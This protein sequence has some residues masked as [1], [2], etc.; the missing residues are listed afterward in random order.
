MPAPPA[1]PPPLVTAGVAGAGARA[2]WRPGRRP[3]PAL[4][5][6]RRGQDAPG[7]AARRGSCCGRGEA[8]P[9]GSRLPDDAADAPVGA[10]RR[11]GSACSCSPT[12]TELR[13][14]RDF[15]GV[16]VTYARVAALG[17]SAGR[18]SAAPGTLVIADEAHH[19]GDELAWG[20]GFGQAFGADAALAAAVGH[21]VSLRRHAD[22]RRALRRRRRRACRT[23]ATRTP[24]RCATASAGRSPSSRT[25]ARCR[26][27][28]GDDVIEAGFDD[29]LAGREASRALP[30]GD[31]DRA[32][33][34]PAADPARGARAPRAGCAPAGTA[35]PAGWSSPPTAS[36]RGA[37]AKVLREVTG[38]APTVVVHTDAR[39]AEQA[40]R[41]SHG[42]ARALDRRGEHGLRGR[43]HPAPARRRLRDGGQDAA[44]LP[45]DR[46]ALRAHDRGPAARAE[47]ALPARPTRCCGATPPRSRREL[48]HVLRPPG[49]DDGLLDEPPE[50]RETRARPRRRTFVPL[51]ADVA[52]QMA[53]FGGGPPA[54]AVAPVA[55][56]AV[57]GARRPRSPARCPPSS[58]AARCATSA[59][60]SSSDLAAHGGPQPREIN[61]WLNRRLRRRQRRRGDP[62]AARALDRAAARRAHDPPLTGDGAPV[63]APRRGSW[64]GLL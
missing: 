47:L 18:G 32:R 49:E 9:R 59:T 7:L 13:P 55:R 10:G 54:P 43:R 2:R 15:H 23:S 24:T 17:A 40:A 50:R 8:R 22:P 46:R 25:T 28:S 33:R 64:G 45:P 52:P 12:P 37:V 30:H 36:T 11:R 48:R 56:R 1:H 62:R 4:R 38:D 44:D 41:R 20:E 42:V 35:T 57:A 21:A 61:A 53:L 5:R 14:P 26:G 60:G 6:A 63:R 19:L 3:V 31:L 58:A 16:A 34:R 51:A 29:V 27:S 39:A